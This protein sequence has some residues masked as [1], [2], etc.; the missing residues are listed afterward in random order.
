MEHATE[1][2]GTIMAL[3]A[4]GGLVFGALAITGGLIMQSLFLP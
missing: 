3:R 4:F 1:R 2:A